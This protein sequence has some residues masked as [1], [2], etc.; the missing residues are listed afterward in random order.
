MP[1]SYFLSV[2]Y[3]TSIFLLRQHM[4]FE[5]VIA[6]YC[7]SPLMNRSLAFALFCWPHQNLGILSSVD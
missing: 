6:I 1:V 5:F 7:T 3:Y 4:F 2:V